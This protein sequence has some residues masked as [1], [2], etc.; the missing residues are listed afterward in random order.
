MEDVCFV[1]LGRVI[2]SLNG[3]LEVSIWISKE[4]E[5]KDILK[6]EYIK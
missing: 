5:K 1:R 6:L 3:C 4:Y 2:T